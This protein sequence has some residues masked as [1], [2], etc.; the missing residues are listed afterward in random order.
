MKILVT[1]GA[2]FI[3]S[4]LV[5]RLVELGHDVR[6][7]DNLEP[8]VHSSGKQPSYLNSHAEFIRGDM[9]NY[10]EVKNAVKDMEIIFHEASV[11]GVGQSMYQIRKYVNV[12]TSGTANLMDILANEN[13]DVKKILVASSMSTYG[14]GAYECESCGRINPQLRP[15]EQ[16]RK[17]DWEVH[18]PKCGRIL[19]PVPTDEG[20]KQERVLFGKVD[21]DAFASRPGEPGTAKVPAFDFDE[22]MRGLDDIK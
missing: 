13:H 8:Q 10:D 17:M 6:I 7:F 4:F 14:E 12:N 19:N 15:E 1:G 3:G 16:M 5:D 2:G 20:K 9:T 21:S 22:A 18:C 11:V